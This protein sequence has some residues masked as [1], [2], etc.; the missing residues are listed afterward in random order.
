MS[1][2]NQVEGCA[3][4]PNVPGFSVAEIPDMSARSMN[5]WNIHCKHSNIIA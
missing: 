3:V 2:G 5:N 4:F 1:R